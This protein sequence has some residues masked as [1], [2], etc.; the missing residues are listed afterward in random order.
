MAL[1]ARRHTQL[2]INANQLAKRTC[3]RFV[4]THAVKKLAWPLR[5]WHWRSVDT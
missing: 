4:A 3:V 1:L 5:V 2:G